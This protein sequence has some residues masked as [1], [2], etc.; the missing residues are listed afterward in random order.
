MALQQ[1]FRVHVFMR[2]DRFIH[3]RKPVL[4]Y[5]LENRGERFS[6]KAADLP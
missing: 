1:M 5:R 3:P 2:L 4:P 6:G